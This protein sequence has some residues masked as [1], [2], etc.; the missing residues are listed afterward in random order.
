[1]K[2]GLITLISKPNKDKHFLDNCRPITLLN[3]D[4]K[5]LA[6]VNAPCI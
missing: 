4:Y 1:M 3:S 6:A 5:I 2:Q